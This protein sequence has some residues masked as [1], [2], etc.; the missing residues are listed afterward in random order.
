MSGV[1][2]EIRR[3]MEASELVAA[4]RSLRHDSESLLFG[5]DVRS[6]N[7]EE[8]DQLERQ[9]NRADDW[10]QLRVVAGFRPEQVWNN[11]FL[12]RVV[13]GAFSGVSCE[14]GDGISLPSGVFDSTVSDSEI[15]DDAV[16]HRVGLLNRTL[17]QTGAAVVNSSCVTC[18]EE[19][20]FGCGTELPLG[21]ETGG[22]EVRS[23]GEITVGV[24][25]QLATGRDDKSLL[26]EF[27][28]LIE[29]YLGRVR[30]S[31]TLLAPGAVIRDS[32]QIVGCYLG[33]QAV[34]S[35]VG[36]L[37][38]S[39]LLST[40][41]EPAVVG[42][43]ASVSGS[44]VQWGAEVDSMAIVDESVLCEHSHVERHGKVTGSIL[45]PNTGVGE[46]EV[47]ASLVGPFVGFHHQALLIAA[48]WP[49]GKGNVGYGANVGSNHTGRAPDQEI[50]CGEGTFFGL[51]VNVKFPADFTKSPYCILASGV[52]CLPQK[53]EFPFSLINAPSR[54][55]DDIPP[56]F[57]EIFPAW[58]LAENIYMI[59]RN[60]GKYQKRNKARRETFVF[61]VFRPEI[62]E[63][64]RDAEHRLSLVHGQSHYSANEIPGLGKNFVTDA[65]IRTAI[66][67]YHFYVGYYAR[68]GLFHRLV[69]QELKARS[70]EAQAL[71]TE[72]SDSARWEQQRQILGDEESHQEVP[73]LLEQLV[74]RERHIA[75]Q[76]ERAKAKD[77]ARGR[78]VI[79]DYDESHQLAA[80]DGFIR[81]TWA[82]FDELAAEVERLLV[83]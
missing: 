66:K 1:L 81:E 12:G 69:C 41:E 79:P 6:L 25:Q 68:R 21:I 46:G 71:L 17:L 67:T 51:G 23:Y 55:P 3:T 40:A 70:P 15:G 24:A 36:S 58:V 38:E 47:T 28:R 74:A 34:V 7:P 76:V 83:P 64:M 37:A 42:G 80:G 50:W 27:D 54:I 11:Q 8:I 39:C 61:D 49:E 35:G 16:V 13:L 14:L 78:K 59:K 56:S 63:L 33:S 19:T 31:R 5:S 30:S 45:G 43:G 22:R 62:I 32:N 53:V 77:D 52:T 82:R 72:P 48:V 9:R 18:G 75:E 26:E 20:T 60:E 57:N 44:I 4:V 29:E 10:T 65:A 2:E 73:A